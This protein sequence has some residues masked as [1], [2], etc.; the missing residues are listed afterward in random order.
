MPGAQGHI[1][2][3]RRAKNGKNGSD[4]ITAYLSITAVTVDCNS[5]GVPKAS[6]YNQIEFGMRKGETALNCVVRKINGTAVTSKT[7]NN[8]TLTYTSGILRYSFNTS[9]AIASTVFEIEL[10]SAGEDAARTVSIAFVASKQGTQGLQ[11]KSLRPRGQWK[12]ANFSTSTETIYNNSAWSDYITYL[13]ASPATIGGVV[14]RK[15]KYRLLDTIASYTM[16]GNGKANIV[17]TDGTTSQNVNVVVPSGTLASNTVWQ[18]FNDMKDISTNFLIADSISAENTST[19]EAFIGTNGVVNEDGTIGVGDAV[20]WAVNSGQIRHTQSGL[21]LTSDGCL[22]DPNG[23][24]IKVG[25]KM[26]SESVNLLPYGN[27][28][29]DIMGGTYVHYVKSCYILGSYTE[30][31]GANILLFN[32]TSGSTLSYRS[33]VPSKRIKLKPNTTYRFYIYGGVA[34][35]GSNTN[36]SVYHTVTLYSSEDAT[37]GGVPHSSTGSWEYNRA[38]R[39]VSSSFTTDDTHTWMGIEILFP[40]IVADRQI[41]ILGLMLSEGSST[42]TEFVLPS[43]EGDTKESL[44]ATGIDI[45]KKQINLFAEML[46]C[47]NLQG[48]KTAWLDSMGNFTIAGVLN[49]LINK[50]NDNNYSSFGYYYEDANVLYLNPLRCGRYVEFDAGAHDLDIT[51]P[52]YYYGALLPT[53][54]VDEYGNTTSRYTLNELRQMVGKSIMFM[55]KNQGISSPTLT[56]DIMFSRH[57][58]YGDLNNM[59]NNNGYYTLQRVNDAIAFKA[60]SQSFFIH[61]HCMTGKYNG[62]ECIYWEVELLPAV[63]EQPVIN[64]VLNTAVNY[65]SVTPALQQDLDN[66][67]KVFNASEISSVYQSN[68]YLYITKPLG[69][70]IKIYTNAAATEDYN[71]TPTPMTGASY[72]VYKI[73]NYTGSRNLYLKFTPSN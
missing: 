39:M 21:T 10:Y 45:D 19:A 32:N 12:S 27:I 22:K 60:N 4:A 71:I 54:T 68:G 31:I 66:N 34:V 28:P 69:Y 58:Q 46:N 62:F 13:F 53:K 72:T 40:S 26:M 61:A 36:Q 30:T 24:S 17:Y 47:F 50:L 43:I 7:V 70:T 73:P 41:A 51:L 8:I 33:L 1:T 2:V 5:S 18:A 3:R 15:M 14:Y 56:C 65:D 9:D 42:L 35:A 37:T 59:D 48:D 52:S 63:I 57:Y 67:N 6:A 44:L 11:G 29:A 16:L 20:G 64:S 38:P 49:N 25:G 23:V 55:P